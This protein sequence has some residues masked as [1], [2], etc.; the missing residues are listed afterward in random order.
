MD[1]GLY[2]FPVLI[3]QSFRK[4]FF[5]KFLV[6]EIKT[7]CEIERCRKSYTHGLVDCVQ[8]GIRMGQVWDKDGARMRLLIG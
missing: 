4:S 7:R 8:D 2:V 6:F 1:C 3:S 5:W